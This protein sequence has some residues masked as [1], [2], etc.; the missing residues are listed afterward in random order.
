MEPRQAASTE[1]GRATIR[2]LISWSEL[3]YCLLLAL[4]RGRILRISISTR[5]LS[6]HGNYPLRDS[7]LHDTNNC[8]I[9][10]RWQSFQLCLLRLRDIFPY[11]SFRGS[12]CD[13][14]TRPIT[15]S[16]KGRSPIIQRG[17]ERP[18]PGPLFLFVCAGRPLIIRGPIPRNPSNID[19]WLLTQIFTTTVWRRLWERQ[20]SMHLRSRNLPRPSASSP[21]DNRAPPMANASQVPDLE[22]LHHEIHGMAEQMRVMNENNARLI[23]LLATA[24]PQP[25]AAPFVP[26]VERSRHSNRSGGRSHNVNTERAR[27]SAHQVRPYVKGV[28]L[29][30][31]VKLDLEQTDPP[32]TERVLG[33]RISSKFKLPTQLGIYEGKTDPM[34]HLDSYK[35]L[36]SV[37]GCSDEVM[38][39]AFSTTLKGPARAKLT[40]NIAAEELAEAKRRRRGKDHKRKEPDTRRNDYKEETRY[41]R[42]DRDT[43]RLNNRRPRTPPRHPEFTLPPLNAPVAQRGYLRKYVAAR[44]PLNSPERRYGDNRPTTGDIQTIHGG[45]GS[46]GYSTSSRK[47][48][49]RSAHGPADD[50]VYN[51]S[52]PFIADQT[53]ITFSNDDLRGVHLP[54]DDALVV[55]AVIANFNVQRILIDNGSSADI[56]F[57]SAFE[58]MKVGPDKLHPFHTPLVGFGENTPHPLGWINLPITLGTE[59][60]QTTVWQDFIVNQ[61]DHFNPPPEDEIPHLDGDRRRILRNGIEQ[62]ILEDP[63]ETENTKPLEEVVPISIHPNYPDRQVMIGSELTN[64][65]RIALIDFLKKNSDVFAWSQGDVPGIDPEVAMHKLFTKPEYSLRVCVDFTDLNKA[66]LKD[67]FPLPKIDLIVDATSKHELLSF[68]DAFSGYHQIKMYPPNVEKTSFITERGLYCYKVMPFGLKNAGATYQ[69]LVNKM[70][71]AQIGKTME[72]YIDDMLVKSLQAHNHIAHLEEAFDI[73]RWHKMMLNPSKCIFGVSFGKFLG[74]LVT[75]RG[76]K[77][78]PDQ[79]QALITMRSPR[80]IR[81][82]QQLTGRVAALNRFL[83]EYLGSLPLL[84]IPTADEDLYVYLSASP[85][86]INAV[87]GRE[88]G[89]VQKPIYYVSKT[90]I[91]AEARYP[92]IE[93]IAYALMIAA[94]KLRHYFQAHSIIVLTDQPLKQILQRPDTSGRLLKWPI[95]LSEFHIEYRPRTAIKAQALA[96]FIVK[97]THEDTQPETTPLEAGILKEPTSEKDLAHWIL[98]VDGSSNQHGCGAGLVIRAPSGEQM[99]YA[100]RMGFQATNNEAEYKALLAGLRVATE[101][102]AQSLEVFSDSQL[103]INQ[104]QGDYLTK[105]SRM[106]A[107]LGEADALANLASTFEFISDRCIPL[108]FLANPSIGIA[109]QI[110]Q[111]E[112]NPTWMDEIIAYLQKGILPKD[113]LQARRLLYRSARFCIFKGKLYKRSFSGPLLRCLRPEKAEYV[114]REIH[115]G[116]CGNHFGARSLARKTIRQ[117]YFW[118][119]I[120]RDAAAYVKRCDKCQRFAPVSRLPHTEMVPMSSPWPFAQWGIDILGPLPQAPLQRKFLIVAIDYFI[121]W[122]EAQPLAK[123]TE[124]NTRDFVWK[125]LVCRFGV[126]KVIISDNARQFDN[127][128][129]RLFCSDLAISH[130]FSSP[131][132]PQANGQVGVTNCTILRNLKARLERSKSMPSFRVSNFNKEINEA[133]LRVNLDLLEEKRVNAE[134]RQMAYKCQVAKYYN[135]RVKHRSFLPGDL[136][137]RKVT[138]STKEPNAG[139]LGPMWK[140]PY[141]VIKV[142]RPGTY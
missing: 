131:G 73:L 54:H 41:K 69:R 40:S 10:S 25:P 60:H 16:I 42:P 107:Y 66:C 2:I 39:K 72:V 128:R 121:K 32:F 117:G 114:L 106:I 47:R 59:P 118:P 120:E 75:K 96:D 14:W 55:S 139:K 44:L 48:H 130:H 138:L 63:R 67:S 65:L 4:G 108:E 15:P 52:S 83:K 132:H 112:E 51:L 92:R 17:F 18:R 123:I 142:S 91:G 34:D 126:S 87:L 53:P 136:V 58:K 22:G 36:M 127:D 33:A 43:K 116:I 8:G 81:E 13:P 62:L 7:L 49:A 80:N 70:F 5:I 71:S 129:F 78:N 101:L 141:K 23:Q 1:L 19:C 98:F 103:V 21:L 105:D 24:A 90:L 27:G 26:D 64:E 86:A 31:L 124:K 3:K 104:V 134:L 35:S 46:G 125:H 135:Q 74:F 77:V 6:I 122:I 37:Q 76:I 82:V 109:N 45:F 95:E 111:T 84:S 79:I 20:F 30:S 12:R 61:G 29:Q 85:T 9:L 56:L 102:G 133:E 57:I 110:L 68:M 89:K 140:G 38:C 113:K 97:F 115:E 94:R 88:E 11:L 119:T 100:I 28:P 137:L 50:E 93:R 99:E